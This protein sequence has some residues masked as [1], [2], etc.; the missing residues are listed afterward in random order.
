MPCGF[1]W[2]PCRWSAVVLESFPAKRGKRLP[3]SKATCVP[4]TAGQ[5][6]VPSRYGVCYRAPSGCK[7]PCPWSS[8]VGLGHPLQSGIRSV[9]RTDG[10]DH[11]SFASL[12][13]A[14]GYAVGDGAAQN[15]CLPRNRSQPGPGVKITS[16][17]RNRDAARRSAA[18]WSTS[19]SRRKTS[20]VHSKTQA[21]ASAGSIPTVS[22]MITQRMD[23]SGRSNTGSTV[24]SIWMSSQDAAR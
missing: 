19:A 8:V 15:T 10:A 7:P 5:A 17:S 16:R 21:S 4:D 2:L 20:G 24:S 11:E 9:Q 14:D 3:R 13:W 1:H 6:L 18:S 23:V 22:T 12:L